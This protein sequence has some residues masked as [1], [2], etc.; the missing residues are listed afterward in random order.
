MNSLLILYRLATTESW[1]Y[2][3]P[4][5]CC[6]PG[7]SPRL[8]FCCF[9]STK[10]SVFCSNIK[11]PKAWEYSHEEA[12]AHLI[13]TQQCLCW[14]SSPQ[15]VYSFFYLFILDYSNKAGVQ[16]G[17]FGHPHTSL[18]AP[19]VTKSLLGMGSAVRN[20]PQLYC[21]QPLGLSK[22]LSKAKGDFWC[23]FHHHPPVSETS[24]TCKAFPSALWITFLGRSSKKRERSCWEWKHKR[25]L[26][27]LG[28]A[29]SRIE[30]SSSAGGLFKGRDLIK[31]WFLQ[32]RCS[33][34]HQ[35]SDWKHQLALLTPSFWG[36]SSDRFSA[37]KET[38]QHVRESWQAPG[39]AGNKSRER[40]QSSGEAAL[41]P[42]TPKKAKHG[43]ALWKKSCLHFLEQEGKKKG[44]LSTEG[45]PRFCNTSWQPQWEGGHPAVAVLL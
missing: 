20:C 32:I 40:S 34:L 37:G 24:S 36:S 14:Q 33:F 16:S 30:D 44:H 27:Q 1:I 13:K 15:V 6:R 4:T 12:G 17:T 39:D 10:L 22:H 7:V 41:L 31:P 38:A 19:A 8:R 11:L 26:F 9:D 23:L 21:N 43:W 35:D 45:S 5:S 29:C 18:I 2:A 3:G 42:S 25:D 28:V